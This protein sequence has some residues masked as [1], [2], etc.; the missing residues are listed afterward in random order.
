MR[1]GSHLVGPIHLLIT[2]LMMPGMS[3][4]ELAHDLTA[5]RPDMRLIFM[6][7]NA[8]ETIT[9]GG[10]LDAGIVYLQKPFRLDIL[11]RTVR[12]VL[13]SVNEPSQHGNSPVWQESYR[14]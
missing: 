9:H 8:Q 5:S 14:T 2:D 10:V 6:S 13:D 1:V 4:T 7:G 11:K 3:G 12:Q